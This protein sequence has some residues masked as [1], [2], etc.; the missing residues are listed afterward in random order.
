MSTAGLF[1]NVMLLTMILGAT[2]LGLTF[3]YIYISEAKKLKQP[4]SKS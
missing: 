1:N 3:V 2:V 4:K